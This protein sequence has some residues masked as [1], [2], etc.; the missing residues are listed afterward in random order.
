MA[1]LTF[2]GGIHPYDGKDLSKDKP[3]QD[4]LPKG[5]MV[6]P[7]SQHIGAPAKP[8]VAKGDRVLAGQKIAESGGFVSAPIY[9]SVS[10]TVK[11]IETRR[12]VTGDLIQ[13]IVID[14]DGLYESM[15][16]HPY[17]P[18]DKLQKDEIID[19][20]K[21]AGVVGMGGAGFPTHVKLSP[22]DPDKIDYVIANCA[23]CEPYL[24][25]DYRRMM[26]EPD[27]LIGGLKIMLK[28][29]D[30]AHGIL[31]VEDNKPDCISLLKQMTKNDPQITVKALKT[32]YPQGAERQLIYATTGRKINSS[33]LPADVGCIVDNVDTVVAIYRAVTEGR[34]LMERIVT[35]TGDAVANP[36]NFRVPI[37]MSYQEL[38]DVAGGFKKDPEKIICGGPM[39]GFG[40]F[41]LNVPTTKT[42]TALLALTQDDV[43]AMEPSPCINCGRCVEACPGRIV[44]SL[45]A[46]YAEHFDEESFVE[47]NGMECCECGCCSFVCPAAL[48][49]AAGF[50][51]YNFGPRALAVMAMTIASTVLT[52]LLFGWLWKKKITITDM[53][54]VVTGLL[55]AL[56]LPVSIPLWM[57]ALGGVF[58]ILVV[59]MLFGGLGQNFM[60]PALAARCFL[61]ISFPSQ[62]TNFVCDA[63]TGATPLAALKAGESVNVMNMIVGKTAGTIGETSVIA[64]LIGACFLIL[65][66]VID[67]RIPGTYIVTVILF[68]GFFG[69]HGF[70]PAYLSAQLAGGG[71]ILGAFFMATD[72]VTRPITI[73]G[74]Y[75]YGV[76][77]GLLT[78]IFRIFGPGAEGVSYAIILGNL[79]VPLIEKFTMP[80]AFGRKAGAKHEK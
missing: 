5:E 34:P 68:A 69:G 70:D 56:N 27:K 39:M 42:S 16:F 8:I 46:T 53:S 28:L 41:D 31:A 18:V 13:S 9:A 40:M 19:I 63:Y 32:K 61:L 80:V 67:L 6:Y 7:M 11:S 73:K 29:F 12:V 49:P 72:Y 47:H 20:V 77:L 3:I 55:L 45:L 71:L 38:L 25:S 48:L 24:T 33:M 23:E 30:N 26:E 51:I 65:I 22:K 58:A 78:G 59:K 64:L 4:V 2:V 44:P 21:E 15:E 75:V 17:A 54:A 79:L 74:Q 52:E 1:K 50:G 62:M 60:N 76:V 35:V 37:G 10:G 36:R 43:S 14:N 57:A 66:G